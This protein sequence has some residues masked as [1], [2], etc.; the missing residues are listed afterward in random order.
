MTGQQ[1]ESSKSLGWRK[2]L[3][4]RW[5]H[6]AGP[7]NDLCPK[8]TEIAVML[9]GKAKVRRRG[10]GELQEAVG[11][12][13]TIWLCPAGIF[14]EDILISGTIECMHLYVDPAEFSAAALETFDVDPR[15]AT[16]PY[17][18][19]FQDAMIEQIARVMRREMGDPGA[20]SELLIDSL[21]SALS[22]YLL[23]NY[24]GIR[25]RS[26]IFHKSGSLD[27]KR[28]KRVQNYIRSHIEEP[29]TLDDLAREACLSPFHFSR[30]FKNATGLS[31]VQFITKE[32]IDISKKLIIENKCSLAEIALATGFSSQDQFIRS[33][34]KVVGITPGSYRTMLKQ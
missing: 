7:L 1:L 21:R 34:K 17:L 22:S 16:L 28:L 23:C 2:V 19:G 8:E 12:P 20:C 14:E 26:R 27:A 6:K 5:H 29:I 33:F 18:G 25:S 11:I 10:N 4:E 31:P 24:S 13:G 9:S 3:T 15:T 30:A 32:K